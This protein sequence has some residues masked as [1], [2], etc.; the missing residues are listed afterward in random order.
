[1]TSFKKALVIAIALPM[2]LGSASALAFGGGNHH[3][4]KGG[5]GMQD[6]RKVFSQLD[7]TDAQKE[8]MKSMR[9]V[10]RD[11]MKSKRLEKHAEMKANHDKMQELVLASNFDENA[12]RDLAQQM[13]TAQVERRVAMLEKRHEMLNILTPEQKTQYQTL[14]AERAE[15]CQAR[16]ADRQ[17]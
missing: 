6:G 4:G 10:N 13:S 16:M 14:Q 7:L 9:E 1:M 3:G 8:Q 2:A 17:K 11:E 15:K 12:V 5:C